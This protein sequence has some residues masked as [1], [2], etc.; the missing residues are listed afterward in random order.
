MRMK[1]IPGFEGLYAITLGGRVWSFPKRT[2]SGKFL[3]GKIN[4][5][6]GYR[7]VILRKDNKSHTR[8]I[9]RLLAQAFIPNPKLLPIVNH[10]NFK[11]LDNRLCN[12]EWV[13]MEENWRHAR[14]AGRYATGI[15]CPNA[16]LSEADVRAIRKEYVPF[17][18]SYG[19]LGKK[20]GVSSQAIVEIVK[21][22]NWK[23]I[24]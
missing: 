13:T 23:Q 5:S 21:K 4:S 18:N 20:Y 1:D 8:H 12:L 11:R 15:R 19:K 10:K 7:T 3:S 16:K 22:R 6:I 17:I 9:H 14:D 2:S 24:L